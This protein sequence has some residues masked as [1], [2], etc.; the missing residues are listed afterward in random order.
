MHLGEVRDCTPRMGG[1][2][3]SPVHVRGS[4]RK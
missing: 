3:R 2:I 4:G 1:K